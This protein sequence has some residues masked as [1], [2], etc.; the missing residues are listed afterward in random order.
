MVPM[1]QEIPQGLFGAPADHGQDQGAVIG[2]RSFH[3]GLVQE[4]K[5]L[6]GQKVFAPGTGNSPHSKL[7]L[8][9]SF[10]CKQEFPA[11]PVY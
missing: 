9:M 6:V 3:Q 7:N 4:E 8:A 1:D 5:V 11:C 10:Q 2:D